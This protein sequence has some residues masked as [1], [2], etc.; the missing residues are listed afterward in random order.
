MAGGAARRHAWSR[1]A[2][3]PSSTHGKKG[4]ARSSGQPARL[5]AWH[6]DDGDVRLQRVEAAAGEERWSYVGKK[7]E[8]RWVWHAIAHQRGKVW[9]YVCGQRQDQGFLKLQ[10]LLEPC[11][12]QRYDTASWGASPWHLDPDEPQPGKRNTQQ[13]ERPHLT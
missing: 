4:S 8:P 3:P 10:G 1:C 9:A 13:I 2:R 12:L 7:R 6:P 11:G 5:N